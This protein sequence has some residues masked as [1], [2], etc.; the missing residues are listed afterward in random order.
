MKKILITIL[1]L[2]MLVACN[3]STTET[4]TTEKE[5]TTTTESTNTNCEK[6]VQ[7]EF[8]EFNMS[9]EEVLK[10]KGITSVEVGA[11]AKGVE[12]IF[13]TDTKDITE[14]SFMEMVK[15][16]DKMFREQNTDRFEKGVKVNYAL[17]YQPSKDVNAET[18][19]TTS[20]ENEK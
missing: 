15:T 13:T 14:E 7:T 4:T 8:C 16:A 3:N 6:Y 9:V 19:Y 18:L 12:V 11:F 17:Y 20:V 2:I 10:D 5:T 1:G